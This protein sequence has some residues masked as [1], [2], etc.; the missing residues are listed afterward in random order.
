MTDFDYD[1]VRAQPLG[2]PVRGPTERTPA[3][4]AEDVQTKSTRGE[5][6]DLETVLE[7]LPKVVHELG[8]L[9]DPD[10]FNPGDVV[11]VEGKRHKL[12]TTTELHEI[13]GAFGDTEVAGADGTEHWHGVS[14]SDAVIAPG[15]VGGFG[16][17]PGSNVY[18]LG[19]DIE[20]D[21]VTRDN[22]QLAVKESAM[23][24]AIGRTPAQGDVIGLIVEFYDPGDS[25]DYDLTLGN[26]LFH[27]NGEKYIV[28][29]MALPTVGS[30]LDYQYQFLKRSMPQQFTLDMYNGGLAN[31]SS[32]TR[33]FATQEVV[34]HWVEFYDERENQNYQ[35]STLNSGRLDRAE[36]QI[37]QLQ[38]H[39]T[40]AGA[41]G[42]EV[43]IL[44]RLPHPTHAMP[45]RAVV[46]IDPDNS[47]SSVTYVAKT[48]GVVGNEWEFVHEY[49]STASPLKATVDQN[50]KRITIGFGAATKTIRQWADAIA[51]LTDFPSDGWHVDPWY[52]ANTSVAV[53]SSMP[54]QTGEAKY[55][56]DAPG[57]GLEYV[58]IE[59]LYHG[60]WDGG[61]QG[62]Y[63]L[64]GLYRLQD[65]PAGLAGNR[66]RAKFVADGD[67]RGFYV[68][69]NYPPPSGPGHNFGEMIFDPTG[70][71]IAGMYLDSSDRLGD[72]VFLVGEE[73]LF[74]ALIDRV[75]HIW[76]TVDDPRK[77]GDENSGGVTPLVA[78]PH[79]FNPD[80]VIHT[81]IVA[82]FY[83]PDG[84]K[85]RG[86]I[87]INVTGRSVVIGGKKFRI[88]ES[89]PS[90]TAFDALVTA[91]ADDGYVDVEMVM[92][93][94]HSYNYVRDWYWPMAQS[95]W[96]EAIQ[97][98]G[99]PGVT[100]RT[101]AWVAIDT[102]HPTVSKLNQELEEIKGRFGGFRLKK[103]SQSDYDALS[104]KDGH[105]I[106]FTYGSD[107]SSR[108]IYIGGDRWE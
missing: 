33:I 104:P 26:L 81:N 22:L 12:A 97:A 25:D 48:P 20:S 43:E 69:A 42:N 5:G 2:A 32:A 15:S 70:G 37:R 45:A 9:P 38:E 1:R 74:T 14:L 6:N 82:R 94:D 40:P 61:G 56:L 88:F 58:R 66:F 52:W 60:Y 59:S 87:A 30:V 41:D 78:N 95:D 101:K 51:A 102:W 47:K 98:T 16:S 79:E 23:E 27:K 71:S 35:T 21:G 17:N 10:H 65:Y 77:R 89:L 92:D 99:T 44:E 7:T 34:K 50:A 100:E 62:W 11:L 68:A 36:D 46:R 4:F 86:D 84:T 75:R 55:G 54:T 72:T 28:Y 29:E 64:P 76:A 24:E 83:G 31:A 18:F 103:M 85:V 57:A 106:Y 108:R 80:E 90:P 13:W 93:V 73:F 107:Q 8:E 67:W 19:Y 53:T 96:A 49:D 105:T 3:T 39:P 91:S 63:N